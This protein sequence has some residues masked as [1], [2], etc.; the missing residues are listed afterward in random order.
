M[1][2]NLRVLARSPVFF[3]ARSITHCLHRTMASAAKT[4]PSVAVKYAKID[5][6]EVPPMAIGEYGPVSLHGTWGNSGD[7]RNVVLG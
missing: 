7:T 4:M 5:G 2:Q 3:G 1:I 6:V